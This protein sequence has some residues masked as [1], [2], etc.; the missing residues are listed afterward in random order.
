MKYPDY[1]SMG[2]DKL[3]EEH[4]AMFYNLT[5]T[6]E[7]CTKL[8]E[9]KRVL[10]SKVNTY[11]KEYILPVFQLGKDIGIDVEQLVF[12]NPGKNCV[13]LFIEEILKKR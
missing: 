1:T 7:K 8:V 4:K 11:E 3:I 12:D 2:R 10:Q 5:Q 9:E 13:E 6:Q